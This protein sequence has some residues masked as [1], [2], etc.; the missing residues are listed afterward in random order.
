MVQS[1]FALSAVCASQQD[2]ASI[3]A[4]KNLLICLTEVSLILPMLAAA[5]AMFIEI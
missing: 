3:G 4:K 1:D 2:A 5:F